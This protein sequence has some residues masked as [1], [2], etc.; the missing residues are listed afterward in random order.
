MEQHMLDLRRT[1]E[2]IV[3][4]LYEVGNTWYTMVREVGAVKARELGNE[5]IL[6]Q[7]ANAEAQIYC[8]EW[9][10]QTDGFLY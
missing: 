5:E 2:K 9:M 4:T 7:L 8:I 10:I 6:Q 1:R 3:Q